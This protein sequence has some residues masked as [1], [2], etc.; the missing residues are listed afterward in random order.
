MS[1]S[2]KAKTPRQGGL[3]S[4]SELESKLTK[5]QLENKALRKKLQ[6][7]DIGDGASHGTHILTNQQ[8]E[9]MIVTIVGQLTTQAKKKLEIRIRSLTAS[10]LTQREF[11]DAVTNLHIRID[12]NY[13]E[14]GERVTGARRSRATSRTRDKSTERN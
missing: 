8:K 2:G 7:Q 12:L 13:S 1:L 11:T 4:V 3:P 5:L 14:S 9:A 10:A 6:K